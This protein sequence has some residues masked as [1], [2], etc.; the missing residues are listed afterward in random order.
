MHY[1]FQS[2]KDL[3]LIHAMSLRQLELPSEGDIAYARG[4]D[5]SHIQENRE[6]FLRSAGFDPAALTLGRQIHGNQVSIVRRQDRGR[7]QPPAFDA[8]PDSDGLA[9]GSASVALGTIVADCVPIILYDP[10]APALA[11]IHAGWRGTVQ[12][13]AARAVE[14]MQAEFGTEPSHIR[15]GIGPS[16]GPCCYEVG[17]DVIDLWA[18]SGVGAWSGATAERQP[19]PHFDLWSANRMVLE[20]A[21]VESSRIEVAGLCTRCHGDRFFS[22]RSAMA[23]ERPRG[24]MIMVAQ[25]AG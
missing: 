2:L 16:I 13:I 9:T 12:T 19:R 15:A 7:G 5:H 22:H 10:D 24:R 23:G 4:T 20:Q 25:L 1:Q 8:I 3:P 21:G 6:R 14:L 18:S 11:V 17:S